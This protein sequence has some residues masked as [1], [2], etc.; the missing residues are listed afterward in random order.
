MGGSMTLPAKGDQIRRV[1][2]SAIANGYDMMDDQITLFPTVLTPPVITFQYL[3]T[4]L[5]PVVSVKSLAHIGTVSRSHFKART[6]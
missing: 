3:L 4:D 2:R 6:N 5:E 1:I